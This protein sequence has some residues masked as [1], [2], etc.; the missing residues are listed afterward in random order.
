MRIL[1]VT[2]ADPFY[3]KIFFREF[4]RIYASREDIKGIVIQK[5][6]NQDTGT[7][8]MRKALTL[9]GP[10][11]FF[12][13]GLEYLGIRALDLPKR[14]LKAGLNDTVG[15]LA[16]KYDIP[17]F[18][19]V[20]VNSD[21]LRD[22]VRS[23]QIDLVVSVAASEVFGTEILGLPPRGCINIHGGLLPK[24]RGMLPNF[25]T[26]YNSEEYAWVTIHRMAEEIDEGPVLIQDRFRIGEK[27]SFESVARRSKEMAALLLVK[28]L[29]MYEKDE[30]SS[31]RNEDV[32]S[33]YYS[34]PRKE[35]IRVFRKRGGR[36]L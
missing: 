2:Q 6:L 35:D 1:F 21:D 20:S 34:F 18:E 14:L 9:Y 10:V 11:G 23:R 8:L 12:L 36:I 17:V 15:Q 5:A 33:S 31:F 16:M 19:G 30:V 3:V 29:G 13:K 22:I 4:L 7:G 27:E 28:L 25:W 26:L 32:P 24:Y